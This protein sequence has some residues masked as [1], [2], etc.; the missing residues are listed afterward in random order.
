MLEQLDVATY[1]NLDVESMREEIHDIDK[2]LRPNL[3]K[4]IVL[5]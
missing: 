5:Q 1:T 3:K 4:V 2:S